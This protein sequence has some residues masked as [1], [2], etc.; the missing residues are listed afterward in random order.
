MRL[1]RACR[2]EQDGKRVFP[3]VFHVPRPEDLELLREEL[4]F[5]AL[6]NEAAA[7]LLLELA[8]RP[9]RFLDLDTSLREDVRVALDQNLPGH[10]DYY[11]AQLEESG[12]MEPLSRAFDPTAVGL[13]G[14]PLPERIG[15]L[16]A[17]MRETAVRPMPSPGP[18]TRLEQMIA[19]LKDSLGYEA[20]YILADG[21][22]AYVQEPSVAARLLKPLLVRTRAWSEQALFVKYFLPNELVPR[23]KEEYQSL[24]TP[25]S[26]V[27]II[28]W[29]V[30][31]LVEV[32]RERLRV[33]SE[34]MFDSLTA[35]SLPDASDQVEKCIAKTARP[36]IPREV[37]RLVRRVFIEHIKRVGSYGRLEQ[38]DFDAALD[39]YPGS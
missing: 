16:C 15:S 25:P 36:A 33:A 9:G 30:D 39:W 3:V 22:D 37:I 24:L 14:E 28:R 19:L 35:I 7:A 12:S 18:L 4:Y 8:Y 27:A 32:V 26:K 20:I 34:G 23:I 31:S 1:A 11:I 29:G 13:P 5:E 17:A 21:V 38:R 6:L 2:V 10:L